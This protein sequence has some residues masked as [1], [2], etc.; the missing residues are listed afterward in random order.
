MKRVVFIASVA[1]L[2]IGTGP[3]ALLAQQ[4]E[5]PTA[6]PYV[7]GNPLGLPITPNATGSFDPISPNVKVYGS[8]YSA[9]SC[10]YDPTRGVI[11]VRSMR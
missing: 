10:S 8:I 5:S 4:P 11:V 3:S 2:A 9:E 7:V 6:Q 1:A